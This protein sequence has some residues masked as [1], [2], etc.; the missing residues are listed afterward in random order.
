MNEPIMN[1]AT[2]C[3][4]GYVLF[5]SVS[6]LWLMKFAHRHHISFMP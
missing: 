5:G 2:T 3:Q 1:E 4:L 6:T